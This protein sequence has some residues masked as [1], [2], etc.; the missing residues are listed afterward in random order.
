[1]GRKNKTDN[2]TKKQPRKRIRLASPP[3]GFTAHT[4]SYYAQSIE[5]ALQGR[6]YSALRKAL[7]DSCTAIDENTIKGDLRRDLLDATIK[8]LHDAGIGDDSETR[9]GI[10]NDALLTISS[11]SMMQQDTAESRAATEIIVKAAE[12]MPN[13][14]TLATFCLMLLVSDHPERLC[15]NMFR[16]VAGLEQIDDNG[17]DSLRGL[18]TYLPQGHGITLCADKNTSGIP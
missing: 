17:R 16:R 5:N 8:A 15:K 9:D 11:I 14:R 2:G 4:S 3:D 12:D 1:M 13:Q 7:S 18:R 6:D 10:R